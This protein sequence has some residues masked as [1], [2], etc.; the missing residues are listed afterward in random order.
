MYRPGSVLVD[1][2]AGLSPYCGGPTFPSGL[3][4]SIAKENT[5]FAVP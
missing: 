1:S 3:T 4:R 5:P 2:V